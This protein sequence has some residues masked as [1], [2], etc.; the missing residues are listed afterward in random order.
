MTMPQ[1]DLRGSRPRTPDSSAP[2]MGRMWASVWMVRNLT[3]THGKRES[4]KTDEF[5][6]KVR[7]RGN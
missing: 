1:P 2:G 3:V 7:D 4:V 5:Y 6:A